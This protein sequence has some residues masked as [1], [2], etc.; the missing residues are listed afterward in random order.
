MDQRAQPRWLLGLG[1]ALGLG[2]AVAAAVGSDPPA[3]E[4]IDAVAWVGEVPITRDRLARAEAAAF[5]GKRAVRS[6]DRARVLDR[7][8][9]EE[10][11][12]QRGVA[13]GLVTR[14]GAVRKAVV[15]SVLESIRGESAALDPP[16]EVAM[17]AFFEGH[18]ERF[19]V[20]AQVRARR[21]FVA[22]ATAQA[23]DEAEARVAAAMADGVAF[24][25]AQATFGGS[26]LSPLPAGLLPA[27]ALMNYLGGPLAEAAL[28]LDVGEVSPAVHGG[29]GVSW[30]QVL[31]RQGGDVPSF[32]A[33]RDQ[34]QRAMAR[35]RD[36][37]HLRQVLTRLRAQITVTLTP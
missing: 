31:E 12:L 7:L 10:L 35:D 6:G 34:V 24:E 2:L 5:D 18:S 15:A 9:D 23:R 28:Q 8:V 37:V 3:R 19:R 26:V 25:V 4:G 14:D 17:R 20:P 29:D 30:V 36:E 1:A 27:R 16:D 32:E 33:A 21:L 11:L 22:A 13:L